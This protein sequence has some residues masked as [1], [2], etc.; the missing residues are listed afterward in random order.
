MEISPE[1]MSFWN[2]VGETPYHMYKNADQYM[3]RYLPDENLFHLETVRGE[4]VPNT[5]DVL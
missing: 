4:D 3:W 1:E 5:V 2:R